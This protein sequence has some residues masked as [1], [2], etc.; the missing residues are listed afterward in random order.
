MVLSIFDWFEEDQRRIREKLHNGLKSCLD[1]VF[2]W[3]CFLI[4]QIKSFKLFYQLSHT[5]DLPSFESLFNILE[6]PFYKGFCLLSVLESHFPLYFFHHFL[7]HSRYLR[8]KLNR[9]IISSCFRFESLLQNFINSISLLPKLFFGSGDRVKQLS[10]CVFCFFFNKTHC[11]LAFPRADI[12]PSCL[13]LRQFLAVNLSS[14]NPN[15]FNHHLSS[16]LFSFYLLDF[17]V[18]VD[19]ATKIN[20]LLHKL[21]SQ[22]VN[23]HCIQLLKLFLICERTDKSK[24][25]SVDER[26]SDWLPDL[27]SD[28]WVTGLRTERLLQIFVGSKRLVVP[29][30]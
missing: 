23:L 5:L 3:T 27:V 28:V 8:N 24:T 6:L 14:V 22:L 12:F 16:H 17:Y 25:S 26:V 20:N 9:L 2:I 7:K 13:D 15:Q 19:Q 30:N 10:N 21:R 29:S 4:K 11:L 18:A 1:F